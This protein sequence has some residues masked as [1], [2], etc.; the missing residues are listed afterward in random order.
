VSPSG[1]LI[2]FADHAEVNDDNGAVTI[3]DSKGNR[4]ASTA[5]LAS[6]EGVAWSPRGDEVWFAASS[7]DEGWADQIRA[8]D[9]SGK[10]RMLLR[11]PGITRLHDVFRDGRVL[12]TREEW[13]VVLGFRGPKDT[14]DRDLSWLDAPVLTDFSPDGSSVVFVE[15]GA[16]G[17]S[18]YFIY[19]RKTD[20][21]PP[22]KLG[23]GRDAALSPDGKSVLAL[24]PLNS[25]G[26]AIWPI[27]A[28]EKKHLQNYGLAQI[29][30]PGWTPDGKQIVFGASDG[31][32][33]RVYTQDLEG[34]KPRPI[35]PEIA[36]L[37]TEVTQL[38]SPDGKFVWAFDPQ[39]EAWLYPLDSSSP[40]AAPGLHPDDAWASWGPDSRTAF[41]YHSEQYPLKIFR[42][43][44][45]SGERKLAKE[46]M[47]DD[48]VGLDS[49]FSARV[50]RDAQSFAYSYQRS[51]SELYF[52]TGLK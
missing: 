2:A 16:G 33:W 1:N 13:R 24:E 15:I 42:L 17:G 5:R 50:S 4:I 40:V 39:Q 11:L 22:L 8:L 48:L 43:D 35:T 9:L 34:G 41:V 18:T 31:H 30:A 20:G 7:G 14:R 46:L 38:A 32:G 37:S 23:E 27:G 3:L 29:L 49:V 6:L 51:F 19:V 26:L 52:V 10:Q 47:P 12:L 21:S 45:I 25:P 44:L 36:P 28:G